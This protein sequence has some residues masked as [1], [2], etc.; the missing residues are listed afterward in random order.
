[1]NRVVCLFFLFFLFSGLNAQKLDL[2]VTANN[3]SIA[4][5]IDSLDSELIYFTAKRGSFTFSSFTK[6]EE[7][8]TYEYD[9]IEKGDIK[10]IPGTIYFRTRGEYLR[11]EEIEAREKQ[12]LDGGPRSMF[13]IRQNTIAIEFLPSL[14]YNRAIPVNN[15]TAYSIT[16]GVNIFGPI[17][18]GSIIMGNCHHSFEGGVGGLIYWPSMGTFGLG[19]TIFS[20]LVRAGYRYTSRKGFQFKAFGNLSFYEGVPIPLPFLSIGYSF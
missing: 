6:L 13:N 2:I 9:Y 5:K 16:A 4:C 14:V 3:D 15:N 17:A 7:L 18:I 10:A 19:N 20:P 8:R 12:I 11:N 1:M